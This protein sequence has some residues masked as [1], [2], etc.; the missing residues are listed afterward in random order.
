MRRTDICIAVCTRNRPE[1]LSEALQS[2]AGLTTSDQ[3][4]YHVLVINNGSTETTSQVILDAESNYPQL[5][6]RSV[7]EPCVGFAHARNRATQET[8]APWIAFFDDDQIADPNWLTELW[9]AAQRNNTTCVGGS[10]RLRFIDPTFQPGPYCR[11]MLGETQPEATEQ[12]CGS[13]FNPGTGNLLIKR[14]VIL[15][16][17]GFTTDHIGR[18]EDSILI[19]KLRTKNYA[20]WFTP[21]ALIHHVISPERNH[22]A[23]YWTLAKEASCAGYFGWI[24]WGWRLPFVGIA[25]L[26]FSILLDLPKLCWLWL[27]GTMAQR[28]DQACAFRFNFNRSIADLQFGLRKYFQRPTTANKNYGESPRSGERS[29]RHQTVERSTG[30]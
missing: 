19:A 22:P 29:Y 9:H 14:S 2:L 11:Q 12:Q 7:T 16:V 1:R 17:G 28:V 3:F 20:V 10:V 25:R 21:N 26:L 30:D 8:D 13:E 24:R 4:R 27:F 15:D 5:N 23:A 18:G 6:L